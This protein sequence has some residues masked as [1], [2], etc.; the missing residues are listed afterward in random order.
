MPSSGAMIR[1]AAL[2][3]ALRS[4]LGG[5]DLTWGFLCTFEG[6]LMGFASSEAAA[7]A[8]DLSSAK[9]SA[10]MVANVWGDY[11]EGVGSAQR[12]GSGGSKGFG[13]PAHNRKH[14][15]EDL[16]MLCMECEK[17]KLLVERLSPDLDYLV[18]AH[19]PSDGALGEHVN[20]EEMK[21]ALMTCLS[22]ED[23]ETD[24]SG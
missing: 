5:G 2:P 4:A 24:I 14:H 6:A 22:D 11:S 23:I 13:A 15:Y 17:G 20:L 9:V 16:G 8:F 10:A 19:A 18:C 12:G 1:A 3:E 7:A 21:R